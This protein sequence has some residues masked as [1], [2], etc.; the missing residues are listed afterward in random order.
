MPTVVHRRQNQSWHSMGRAIPRDP[1]PGRRA[2]VRRAPAMLPDHVDRAS[3]MT[4]PADQGREL[5]GPTAGRVDRDE[6]AMALAASP[7]DQVAG[8]AGRVETTVRQRAAGRVPAAWVSEDPRE[9]TR[10]WPNS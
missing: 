7:A 1:M 2:G 6:T 8:R 9:S 5:A 4:M 10:K 3:K